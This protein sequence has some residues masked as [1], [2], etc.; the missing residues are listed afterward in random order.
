MFK[1]SPV[2]FGAHHAQVRSQIF[3]PACT[4]QEIIWAARSTFTSKPAVNICPVAAV[5]TT[6]SALTAARVM[7]LHVVVKLKGESVAQFT[8]HH[9]MS[10]WM[11]LTSLK[12][13]FYHLI[14]ITEA[15]YNMIIVSSTSTIQSVSLSDVMNSGV[16]SSSYG[17]S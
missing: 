17:S 11:I 14:I 8:L 2:M 4:A 16:R 9:L 6:T 1:P 5:T 15:Y 3:F 10:L 7:P 12:F 13:T